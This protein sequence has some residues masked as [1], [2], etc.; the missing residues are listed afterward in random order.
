[1][2]IAFKI[3]MDSMFIA[4]NIFTDSMFIAFKHFQGYDVYSI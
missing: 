1:M 2:F 4:L 3:F